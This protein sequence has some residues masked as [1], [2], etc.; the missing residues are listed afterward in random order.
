MFRPEHRGTSLAA[1]W[2][3]RWESWNGFVSAIRRVASVVSPLVAAYQGWHAAWV[4]KP[5]AEK[6][7]W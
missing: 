7:P 3:M 1:A 4:E 2:L 5:A 6:V